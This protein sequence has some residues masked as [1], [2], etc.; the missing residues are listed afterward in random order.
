[1]VSG[2]EALVAEKLLLCYAPLIGE[3][4][5]DD[6]VPAQLCG[7]IWCVWFV[8]V[9]GPEPFLEA[10]CDGE[11]KV[12]CN[13]RVF[14]VFRELSDESVSPI[15]SR[16]T[17]VQTAYCFGLDAFRAGGIRGAVFVFPNANR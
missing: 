11:S 3:V 17:E 15:C 9:V 1:M 4:A 13:G 6:L 2:V 8:R 14:G 10:L 16:V 12:S 5:F 7:R